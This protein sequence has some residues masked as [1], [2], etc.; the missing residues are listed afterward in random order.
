ML[1]VRMKKRR[2]SQISYKDRICIELKLKEGKSVRDIAKLLKRSASTISR[3]IMRNKGGPD[4]RDH[5]GADFAKNQSKFRKCITGKKN[6]EKSKEELA[7]TEA[8]LF[9]GWTPEQ[10]SHRIGIDHPGF[11][12]SHETIYQYV[13]DKELM[14]LLPRSRSWKRRKRTNKRKRFVI[15]NRVGIE[16]RGS[17]ANKREE[18]GHAE[19]DAIVSQQS[20]VALNVIVDRMTRL[21]KITKISNLKPETTAEAIIRRLQ[22]YPDGYCKTATYDNGFENRNHEKV[23]QALAIKSYFCNPYHSWEKGTVENTNALIRR[24]FPKKTDF[25]SITHERIKE[26]ENLLN[27]RP[28][29]CLGFKTPSEVLSEYVNHFY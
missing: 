6:R 2:Y 26:V 16:F 23:N 11:S 20:K 24:Y 29:K 22:E 13:A 14:H 8:K 4:P 3:E 27:N 5:Y 28:R 18:A 21:V 25:S 1:G 17:L 12:I 9:I 10:I 15:A 7:Y 19:I